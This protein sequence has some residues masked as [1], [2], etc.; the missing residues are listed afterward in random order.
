MATKG[1]GPARPA[2]PRPRGD[3][4]STAWKAP[5]KGTRGTPERRDTIAKGD[6]LPGAW[7]NQTAKP[8]KLTDMS[9][10]RR[11]TR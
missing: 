9:A 4:L 6:G 1:S 11:K 8:S 2:D 3:G 7:A 5:E 10:A